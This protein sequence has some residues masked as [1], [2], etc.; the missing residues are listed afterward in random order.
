ML[1]G[2]LSD[3]NREPLFDD[4]VEG[5]LVVAF[6]LIAVRY[7]SY[8]GANN[9]GVLGILPQTTSDTASLAEPYQ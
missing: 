5:K 7:M 6:P 3:V 9:V 4:A 8:L 1:L 2:V